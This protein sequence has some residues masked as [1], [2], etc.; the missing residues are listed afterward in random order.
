MRQC[1][2]Q[3][4]LLV[5]RYIVSNYNIPAKVLHVYICIP[6]LK[7]MTTYTRNIFENT[8]V[9][10][11]MTFLVINSVL[12]TFIIN[13]ISIWPSSPTYQNTRYYSNII[14]EFYSN[15]FVCKYLTP[16]RVA[17]KHSRFRRLWRQ[18]QEGA[19]GYLLN[20]DEIFSVDRF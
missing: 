12:G 17:N 19:M 15:V 3:H 1:D 2:N 13:L 5:D 4:A 16:V 6:L 18:W 9:R 10:T 14:I 8:Q 11:L 20:V 7:H